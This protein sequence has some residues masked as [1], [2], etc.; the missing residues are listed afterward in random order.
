[1]TDNKGPKLEFDDSRED[2]D[3]GPDEGAEPESEPQRQPVEGCLKL[4]SRDQ[5]QHHIVLYG[6][7]MCL[8]LLLGNTRIPQ[9]LHIPDAVEDESHAARHVGGL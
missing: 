6:L 1:M 3:T 7:G 5:L 8:G 4:A 2:G 9:T